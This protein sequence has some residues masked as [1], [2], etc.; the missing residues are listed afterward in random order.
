MKNKKIK[1]I[2]LIFLS[3]AVY[4]FNKLYTFQIGEVAYQ[5]SL[6]NPISALKM[7]LPTVVLGVLIYEIG[8]MVSEEKVS[9]GKILRILGGF[10]VLGGVLMELVSFI[11]FVGR[12]FRC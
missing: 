9:L 5:M 8:A 10:H 11:I 6:C 12:F 3:L 4:I 1:V 2:L 7:V